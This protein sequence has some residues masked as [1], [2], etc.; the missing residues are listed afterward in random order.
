TGEY[1]CLAQTPPTGGGKP[2]IAQPT[3]WDRCW[4]DLQAIRSARGQADLPGLLRDARSLLAGFRQLAGNKPSLLAERSHIL[5]GRADV[6]RQALHAN[7]DG[8][9]ERPAGA[10][11]EWE[12]AV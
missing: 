9:L 5:D 8:E 6:V 2:M 7:K 3:S 4:A 1:L 12:A 11:D 10:N